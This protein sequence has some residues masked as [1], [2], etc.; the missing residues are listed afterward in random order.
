[1]SLI[2]YLFGQNVR[3]IIGDLIYERG[4]FPKSHKKN[5]PKSI[6]IEAEK[7]KKRESVVIGIT[8]AIFSF[9]WIAILMLLTR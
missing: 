8:I 1:M 7:L 5:I 2:I 6:V 3:K 4:S 9:G